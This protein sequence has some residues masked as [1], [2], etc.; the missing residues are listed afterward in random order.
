MEIFR[1]EAFF[2]QMIILAM[3]D[4]PHL[5]PLLF[6]I[7]EAFRPYCLPVLIITENQSKY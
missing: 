7:R 6:E 1:W 5:A 4:K 2:R 3:G